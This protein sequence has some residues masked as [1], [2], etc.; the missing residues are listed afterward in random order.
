MHQKYCISAKP[1]PLN[2]HVLQIDA[3]FSRL[4]Q[5]R[6]ETT[7]AISVTTIYSLLLALNFHLVWTAFRN[8][9]LQLLKQFRNE[10]RKYLFA[11]F[12]WRNFKERVNECKLSNTV[13]TWQYVF[14]YG[15]GTLWGR[16]NKIRYYHHHH[17]Y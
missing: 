10:T 5:L 15:D 9:I 2:M 13:H 8:C 6:K 11:L 7:V 14:Y 16:G 3:I 1:R 4:I 12:G 17:H